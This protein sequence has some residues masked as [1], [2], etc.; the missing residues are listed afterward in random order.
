M[1]TTRE[2]FF[3]YVICFSM[4]FFLLMM[5]FIIIKNTLG[6][7]LRSQRLKFTQAE[8][9]ERRREIERLW[10]EIET[11]K[12]QSISLSL[13]AINSIFS[14]YNDLIIGIYEGLFDE[15]YVKMTIGHEIL[16]FYQEYGRRIGSYENK[17][18]K[19]M[20]MEMMLKKWDTEGF[21]FDSREYNHGRIV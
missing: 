21:I 19:S 7:H 8:V 14:I 15:R 18:G 2:Y 12:Y 13:P 16:T 20:A 10:T 3:L 17:T 6:E 5:A 9:K 11:H 1:I 4:I